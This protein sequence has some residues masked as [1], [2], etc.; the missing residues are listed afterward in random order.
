MSTTHAIAISSH[1]IN[2][3]PYQGYVYLFPPP[4]LNLFMEIVSK[5]MI[6]KLVQAL[7]NSLRRI[8]L[9]LRNEESWE[10]RDEFANQV[11]AVVGLGVVVD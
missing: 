2:C 5:E 8:R 9:G 10:E 3:R 11:K 4:F 7:R 6:L 1:S